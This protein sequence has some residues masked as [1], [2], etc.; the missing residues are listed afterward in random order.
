[1]EKHKPLN[2]QDIGSFTKE[3][4]E[5]LADRLK[6]KSELKELSATLLQLIAGYESKQ[7]GLKD[8]LVDNAAKEK[9]VKSLQADVFMYRGRLSSI[10]SMNKVAQQYARQEDEIRELKEKSAA[11]TGAITK[12]ETETAAFSEIISSNSDTMETLKLGIAER[13]QERKSLNGEIAEIKNVSDIFVK[14]A[15]MEKELQSLTE[16]RDG[17]LHETETVNT[18]LNED[19]SVLPGLKSTVESLTKELAS[20]EKKRQESKEYLA[21]QEVL[22]AELTELGSKKRAIEFSLE[23][24]QTTHEELL[25]KLEAEK[26]KN[27]AKKIEAENLK[28]QFKEFINEIGVINREKARIELIIRENEGV[29]KGIKSYFQENKYIEAEIEIMEKLFEETINILRI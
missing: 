16:K 1:M 8:V 9:Q 11:S 20:L 4:D 10:G 25:A 13:E 5:L 12:Y 15:E 28:K 23:T 29:F 27:A 2:W 18:K 17:I 26:E 24:L 19:E 21:Q 3:A 22:N 7:A 14:K 6:Y